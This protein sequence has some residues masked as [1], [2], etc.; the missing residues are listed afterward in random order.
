MKDRIVILIAI[1]FSL[2]SCINDINSEKQ[3]KEKTQDISTVK[4]DSIKFD[5]IPIIENKHGLLQYI[6]S[7]QTENY[8]IDTNRLKEVIAWEA[9]ANSPKAIYEGNPIILLDFPVENFSNHFT[10]P[11]TYFFAKWDTKDS[12]F[13]NG[14]D[15]LL[16]TWKIDS[17]GIDNELTIYKSLTQ[18]MGNFPCFC[19]RDG[20]RVYALGH[21]ITAL[22]DYTLEETKKIRNYINPTSV[23]YGYYNARKI[24]E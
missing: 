4:A 5:S 19:F 11:M 17:L 15:F 12:T 21:R 22:A 13:K 3:K 14:N 6:D 18:F 24:E 23:I 1:I 10:D 20:N 9:A 8:L 2:T 7:M 16:M